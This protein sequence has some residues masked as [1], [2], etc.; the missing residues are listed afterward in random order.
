[1]R[2]DYAVN[3]VNQYTSRTAPGRINLTGLAA[4]NATVPANL[5]AGQR[6]G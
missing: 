6:H 2:G 1:L 4:N 5:Q 3:N